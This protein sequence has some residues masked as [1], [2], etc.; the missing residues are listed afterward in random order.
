M[1]HTNIRAWKI[2]ANVE[3]RVVVAVIFLEEYEMKF[4]LKIF[5]DIYLREMNVNKT[6]DWLLKYF[7]L[8]WK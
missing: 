3:T 5:E 8:I 6:S 1:D 7:K 4:S 2:R